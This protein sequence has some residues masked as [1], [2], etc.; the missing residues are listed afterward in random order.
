MDW[1]SLQNSI[2]IVTQGV[3]T[4]STKEMEIRQKLNDTL[5]SYYK[6]KRTNHLLAE[7][8]LKRL[9]LIPVNE[10]TNK[11]K[12]YDD[13]L[14]KPIKV[15][16]TSNID[17]LS[18]FGS[19]NEYLLLF[20]NN[21]EL[22]Y[23]LSNYI[24]QEEQYT[25]SKLIIHYF[26]DDITLNEASSVLERTIAFFVVKEIENTPDIFYDSFIAEE[27]FI[28]KLLLEIS[29]R[30][31]VKAHIKHVI[32]DIIKSIEKNNTENKKYY[33]T[34]NINELHHKISKDMESSSSENL[35]FVDKEPETETVKKP[36]PSTITSFFASIDDKKK[37]RVSKYPEIQH[38]IGDHLYNT[39]NSNE[40]TITE[41]TL[42]HSLSN[43]KDAYMRSFY[44]KHLTK[45]HSHHNKHCYSLSSF[46][47]QISSC[48]H[49]DKLIDIYINNCEFILHLITTL[50][51]KIKLNIPF[52]PKI[53]KH[54]AQHIYN[55]LHSKYPHMT[56]LDLHSFISK[57]YIETIIIPNLLNPQQNEQLVKDKVLE[58]KV[59]KSLLY[60][61]PLLKA[62]ARNELFV[63][64]KENNNYT[65]F[66]PFIMQNALN[67]R[68]IINEI[69]DPNENNIFYNISKTVDD[70]GEDIYQVMCLN[71]EEIKIFL[72][73]YNDFYD[74]E[75]I[76]TARY[77]QVFER[78]E[79]ILGQDKHKEQGINMFY[80]FYNE[81]FTEA[82]KKSLSPI[83]QKEKLCE[84]FSESNFVEEIKICMKYVLA[85]TPDFALT[86]D[87]SCDYLFKSL[88]K[89]IEYHSHDYK[90][91]LVSRI[92]L[93]WYSNFIVNKLDLLPS[94][95]KCE[96]YKKLLNELT[97]EIQN[98]EELLSEKNYILQSQ[99]TN[100]LNS[101]KRLISLSKYQYKQIKQQE[102][103]IKLYH[104]LNKASIDLCLQ[105]GVQY[106]ETYYELY[107]KY[108]EAHKEIKQRL[109]RLD[110][111][112]KCIHHLL[113]KPN[114]QLMLHYHH[115]NN[116]LQFI[117]NISR[118]SN[119]II[120]D[121]IC[122]LPTDFTGRLVP[123]KFRENQ[124]NEATKA[125]E[126]LETFFEMIQRLSKTDNEWIKT[127]FSDNSHCS[128]E[129]AKENEDGDDS[130][131]TYNNKTKE[132]EFFEKV[133]QYVIYQICLRMRNSKNYTL[134]QQKYAILSKDNAYNLIY[135][136]DARFENKCK[137]LSWLD[138]IKHLHIKPEL[139]SEFQMKIAAEY[140]DK[141][142]NGKSYHFIVKYLSK[143]VNTLV[144]MFT[145]NLGTG[146]ATIDDFAPIMCYLLIQLRPK[147]AISN[148]G[149]CKYFL[150]K[151]MMNQDIGFQLA[152]LEMCLKYISSIDEK[153]IGLENNK[154][155]Y[156]QK[157]K[158]ALRGK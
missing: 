17:D 40:H 85:N 117:Q 10:D 50:L 157:C 11:T 30:S 102:L 73:R 148:F 84:A 29:N 60:L 4:V 101:L 96:N 128:P 48:K 126:I 100:E 7:N 116:I 28:G 47:Q 31:E 135:E 104:F 154:E 109:L 97:K 125:N 65:L 88:N 1:T 95:Y 6:M 144:N 151:K 44:I 56:E 86:N 123:K 93:N 142:D 138:P 130:I 5:L 134:A 49:R 158:E 61:E 92:P 70:I 76:Q 119:D 106:F 99:M 150:S 113:N 16:V 15:K 32:K 79:K 108:D 94:D 153:K 54:T 139:L 83:T 27:T 20:R 140:L 24:H 3:V 59:N 34:L 72:D 110:T 107:N 67:M 103:N 98:Y 68:S 13:D 137:S 121:I 122:L 57:F 105:N 25:L 91:I 115:S 14:N 66:N 55:N 120:K 69:L 89:I 52:I 145:F 90:D 129:D 45:M 23:R 147:R 19:I 132:E 82:R 81:N 53:I 39:D 78:K 36:K 18:Y 87:L 58:V 2:K 149:L 118:Y 136:I 62:I 112:K 77:Q 143:A 111:P 156:I 26:Y 141:S 146:G 43:E 124:E 131:Y 64:E 133:E 33:L 114:K 155:Y 21:N 38:Y 9:G 46:K 8:N 63:N 74:V 22:M 41:R 35:D 80:L 127:F 42:K 152:N 71:K 51:N 12:K 75:E 37:K